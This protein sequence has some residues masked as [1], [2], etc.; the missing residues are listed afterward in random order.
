MVAGRR[1]FCLRRRRLRPQLP[2][3]RFDLAASGNRRVTPAGPKEA[4]LADTLPN[5]ILP[6]RDHGPLPAKTNETDRRPIPAIQNR[7][8]E[9]HNRRQRCCETARFTS[10]GG[11]L[12]AEV[13]LSEKRDGSYD[14]RLWHKDLNKIIKEWFGHFRN[15]RR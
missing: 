8:D 9:R 13:V 14:L 3:R 11:V 10:D 15:N 12:S 6:S 2:P 7:G 1:I 4:A 5:V